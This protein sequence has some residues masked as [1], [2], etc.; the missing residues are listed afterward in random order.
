MAKNNPWKTAG[1]FAPKKPLK[2]RPLLP[3]IFIPDQVIDCPAPIEL[4]VQV[5]PRSISAA[6]KY[7]EFVT[8]E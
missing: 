7:L 4:F 3:V 6:A 5:G 8:P 2:D 1:E